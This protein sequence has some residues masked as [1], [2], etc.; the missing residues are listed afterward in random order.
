MTD[1]A[2]GMD[3][4]VPVAQAIAAATSGQPYLAG[5]VSA[6]T[7]L[8]KKTQMLAQ[9]ALTQIDSMERVL[10]ADPNLTG[11]GSGQLTAMTN[12]LGTNSE[13]A[14]QFLAAATFLSEHGVGVF[15]GRNIHS[16]QDLQ[17][18]M[19]GLRT[20]PAALRAALEQAKVTMLPW[21]TA[22]GRLPA[23]RTAAPSSTATPGSPKTAADYLKSVG[24]K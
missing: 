5:V 8:D 4:L 12:W 10:K 3:T 17:N 22:G 2:T 9:S 15:G 13:D 23:S 7:G 11:P 16:I 1:P 18:L 19:G 21:A 20:N 14:Q 24:V 6:P